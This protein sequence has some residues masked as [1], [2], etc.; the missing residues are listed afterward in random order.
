M[1]SKVCFHVL[2]I[3]ATFQP[4]VFSVADDRLVK[5][6]LCQK[7]LDNPRTLPCLHSFCLGCLEHQLATTPS[8][9][10]PT[11]WC[12]Q[13][14]AP[15]DAPAPGELTF[16]GC[17]PF[18]HSL[19]KALKGGSV[20]VNAEIRCDLCDEEATM[21]CVDCSENLGPAC[22]SA[23]KKMKIAAN[24]RQIPLD[25]AFAGTTAAKRIFRC[26]HHIVL[27]IDTYC[28]TCSEAVCAKCY[29]ER[30]PK[31]DFCPLSEVT[32]PLQNEIVTYTLNMSQRVEEA[33]E[34][35]AAMDGAISQIEDDR[36]ATEKEIDEVIDAVVASAEQRRIDLK[37]G[38][39]QMK[40][41]VV[42]DRGEAESAIVEFREFRVFT[43]GLLAQGTPHEIAGSHRMVSAGFD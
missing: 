4:L 28:R 5:C 9:S 24:H 12:R 41:T 35:I 36:T 19:L 16:L 33:K 34:A 3:V 14:S 37:Q 18:T 43:E 40:K 31:H 26:Q 8:T 11:F 23:H 29:M 13:C 30:H 42:K 17:N 21:H 20:D 6:L 25:D 7:N 38:I 22:S 10:P 2:P 27:E 39:D 1:A 15:F 32:G